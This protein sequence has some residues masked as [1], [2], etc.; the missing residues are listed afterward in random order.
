MYSARGADSCLKFVVDTTVLVLL[1]Q[2]TAHSKLEVRSHGHKTFV[3][4]AMNVSSQQEPVPKFMVTTFGIRTNVGGLE[5][6]ERV[7]C[8][9]GTHSAVDVRD[10][11]AE[12]SLPQPRPHDEL[13]RAGFSGE[14]V[15]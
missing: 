15:T 5:G 12:S 3:E 9:Y 11:H 10:R 4:E 2:T 8:A 6:G 1:L 14:L 13:N 7:F